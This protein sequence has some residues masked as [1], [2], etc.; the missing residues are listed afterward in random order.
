MPHPLPV[1]VLAGPTSAGK[2][3]AAIHVAHR[4]GARIV[5]ADAMQVYR[6]MDIGTGKAHPAILRLFPHACVDVR[7]L[8]APFSAMDFAAEAERVIAEGQPV[9][10]A[11]GTVFYLRALLYGLVEAPSADRA[12]RAHLEALE[13]P[14][15]ELQ[16]V[17]P[18]LAAR[19]HPHD[20]V[21]IVRGLEVHALTGRPL[22][23]LH[24]EDRQ[25]PRLP[26]RVLW[27]DRQ[28]LRERMDLRVARMMARGYLAEVRHL[29][30]FDWSRDLK[31]MQSLGYRHLA[32]HLLDGL[33]LEEAVWRTRRDTWRFAKKQRGWARQH[34][35]WE[36][37]DATDRAAV[38]AAATALWGAP[39]R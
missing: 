13:D 29:L 33:P 30:E 36:R 18:A 25:A 10:I 24:A 16:R 23:A 8:D 38:L 15:S 21:R 14:W 19:L 20:R 12:L 5:S 31:P 7:D 26:H 22:S 4:W 3:S 17:D 1:L 39:V 11:G 32:D 28:D 34:P 27:L 35:H 9:V 2:T 37:I 6:G